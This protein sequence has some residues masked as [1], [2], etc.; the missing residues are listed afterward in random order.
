MSLF[1]KQFFKYNKLT[2]SVKRMLIGQILSLKSRH[3]VIFLTGVCRGFQNDADFQNC[4]VFLDQVFN[5]FILLEY[6]FFLMRTHNLCY[7]EK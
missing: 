7:V 5:S 1:L 6:F 4:V 3:D 2:L